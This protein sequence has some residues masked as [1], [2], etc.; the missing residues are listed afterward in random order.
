MRMAWRSLLNKRARARV[1]HWYICSAGSRL[2][3]TE[4]V[5][6]AGES[7]GNTNRRELVVRCD[8]SKSTLALHRLL[9][10][11]TLKAML[12]RPIKQHK[13]P[14]PSPAQ[15]T[16][17][18]TPTDSH[19]TLPAAPH[20]TSLPHHLTYSDHWRPHP[21]TYPPAAPQTSL[22][23]HFPSSYFPQTL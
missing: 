22:L 21:T 4:T 19:N 10:F 11:S 14:S 15:P 16:S 1:R 17:T 7:N 13:I 23:H 9:P 8:H 12:S 3:D 18:P 6:R 2:G 20:K 5:G